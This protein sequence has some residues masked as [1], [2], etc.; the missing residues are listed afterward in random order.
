MTS[1]T[2]WGH[3]VSGDWNTAANWT[4]GVPIDQALITTPGTYTVT[5]SVSN[6]I[7]SL[8][9]AKK[10]TVAI[11]AN[12]LDL[13]SGTLNGALAG[14]INALGGTSLVLGNPTAGTTFD[15]TGTVDL[16][17]PLSASG[18]ATLG[19]A[20]D[21]TLTGKG[22]INFFGD[23]SIEAVGGIA[24]TLTNSNTISGSGVIGD[25]RDPVNTKKGVIDG[26]DGE[27]DLG[28]ATNSGLLKSSNGATLTFDS[29]VVQTAKGKI[30]AT[31]SASFPFSNLDLHVTQVFGGQI[32]IAKGAF[33]EATGGGMSS[34]GL[35]TKPIKNAGTIAAD[36]GDLNV[37]SVVKN[38]GTLLAQ[39]HRLMFQTRVIGG[40]A[41]ISGA[42]L[43]EFKAASS[44]N[45]A[46]D[47]GSS[48]V[49]ALDAPALFTGTVTGLGFTGASVDL[50]NI[51]FADNPLAT[52]VDTQNGAVVTVTDPV[53]GT[54]DKLTILGS[55]SFHI[56]M[57]ADGNTSITDPPANPAG[58]PNNSAKLLAQSMAAFGAGGGVAASAVASVAE[59]HRSSDF[60]SANHR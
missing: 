59:N 38:T 32:S 33:L 50:K 55:M 29:V 18:G 52:T 43:L 9:V 14:T 53:T 37:A 15:N 58:V 10:A 49:L 28:G 22:K 36:D 31:T 1:T 57:A 23:N 39:N 2:S 44:A 21:V 26:N 27:L 25:L 19:L 54:T 42:G 20:G 34:I 60:L 35:Q 6:S 3:G 51:P 8:A 4:N 30:E 40:M 46:F 41:E 17:L 45:V 24:P 16:E 13:T 47:P 5:S 56:G 48:G 7:S 12:E 11:A